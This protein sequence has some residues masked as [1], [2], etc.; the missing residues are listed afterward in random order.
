MP[1]SAKSKQPS[2]TT[3]P[4]Q[5]PKEANNQVSYQRPE[6]KEMKKYWDLVNALNDG[7]AA[8]QAAGEK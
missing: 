5:T 2:A 7:T 3:K 6:Y 1:K 4:V 8:M